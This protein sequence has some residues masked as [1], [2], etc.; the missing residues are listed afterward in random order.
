MS[1]YSLSECAE[2]L[3]A[4]TTQN[5]EIL[6]AINKCFY[7]SS[8]Y[9]TTDIDG[10]DYKIPSFLYLENKINELESNF[11]NLV[12]APT[13]GQAAFS[14]DGDTQ[15]IMLQGFQ[16]APNTL[17]IDTSL[18]ISNLKIFDTEAD[19]IFKDFTSP[20]IFTKLQLDDIPEHITSVDVKKITISNTDLTSLIGFSSDGPT[21][22]SYSDVYAA[23]FNYTEDVDYVSYDTRYT[24]PTKTP[25]KE[26]QWTISS[27]DSDT[28]SATSMIEYVELTM[29][30]DLVYTY[31]NQTMSEYISV[32]DVLITYDD[33]CKM[34]VESV[35]VS[36]KYL[37]LKIENGYVNLM[38]SEQD[39]GSGTSIIKIFNDVT[40]DADNRTLKLPLEEDH[41]IVV[42]ISPV[43]T[44]LN[45]RAPWGNGL[46]FDAHSMRYQTYSSDST[47]FDSYYKE[48]IKNIG[49]VLYDIASFTSTTL[50]NIP[51][52]TFNYINAYKPAVTSSTFAVSQTNKHL[53][54][55]V[56]LD[57]IRSL[58]SQKSEIN[59]RMLVIQ[60]ELTEIESVLSTTDFSNMTTSARAVYEDKQTELNDEKNTLTTTL[61]NLADQITLAANDT[62]IP[63]QTAEYNIVGY[64]DTDTEET[65]IS[66][67]IDDITTE[68]DII[69]LNVMYRYKN[70][71]NSV[72]SAV[73]VD[74]VYTYSGW[75]TLNT[76][77][78]PKE[79]IWDESVGSVKYQMTT[80]SE[81]TIQFNTL[82]IPIQPSET[83]DIKIQYQYSL[84]YPYVTVTSSWSDTVSVEFPDSLMTDTDITD[85]LDQNLKDSNTLD[86]QNLLISDGTTEHVQD[87]VVDQDQTYFHKPDNISS[88][89][90]TDDTRRIISLRDKLYEINNSLTSLEEYYTND[91]NKNLSVTVSDSTSEVTLT[92]SETNQTFA[93]TSYTDLDPAVYDGVTYAEHIVYINISNPGTTPISLYSMYWGGSTIDV[94]YDSTLKS[95]WSGV[96]DEYVDSELY[97]VSPADGSNDKEESMCK[98]KLSQFVLFR[99]KLPFQ[100]TEI[101]YMDYDNADEN[102][103]GA[104]ICVHPYLTSMSYIQTEYST[105]GSSYSLTSGLCIS[106]P[107]RVKVY[108]PDEEDTEYTGSDAKKLPVS[109]S[110]WT[111]QYSEPVDYTFY[112]SAPY[113]SSAS[114]QASVTTS[115]VPIIS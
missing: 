41:Y 52:D 42:F 84:G 23:L 15:S 115:Y 17:N 33:N 76:I 67:Y 38:T 73:V 75:N 114:T 1:N 108:Y 5:L 18:N 100:S 92:A 10:E 40:A 86:F 72:T 3:T 32:G 88:G 25:D 64:V 102:A 71:D 22:V 55:T 91:I 49:D 30:E 109:F 50:S 106:I 93:I 31:D 95:K 111:S 105:P 90:Y 107:V 7:A 79:A 46:A 11:T 47:L 87:Y 110:V 59:S 104:K 9:I 13:T 98:Q 12:N 81:Q 103:D 112:I 8:S 66:S 58:N 24:L 63:D 4:L 94:S 34:T 19:D 45:V 43:N 65:N 29:N 78:R 70:T 56:D 77:Y 89:F 101:T 62:Y 36:K 20:A 60:N 21:S 113:N 26:G 28:M 57:N 61:T 39:G 35:D 27:I 16:N 96:Y 80:T 53:F 2:K 48:N 44:Q 14:F 54:D 74:D 37:K 69:K 82:N 85:I 51:E 83:V 6:D 97:V 99:N 68:I